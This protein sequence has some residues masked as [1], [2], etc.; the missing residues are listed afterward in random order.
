MLS[1]SLTLLSLVVGLV[2]AGSVLAGFLAFG[3]RFFGD[4]RSAFQVNFAAGA[5][6][7]LLVGLLGP[8]VAGAA[9]EERLR[10]AVL[11]A[12]P[13]LLLF[14]AVTSHFAVVFKALDPAMDKVFGALM[15]WSYGF[16]LLGGLARRRR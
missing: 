8:F 6:I 5:A 4:G 15:L 2:V 12:I 14:A 11:I 10:A 7:G 16:V 9:G 3:P 1:R 13:G